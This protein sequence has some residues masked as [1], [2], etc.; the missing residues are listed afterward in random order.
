MSFSCECE[1]VGENGISTSC[2]EER[3]GRLLRSKGD[4]QQKRNTWKGSELDV[5]KKSAQEVKMG[6]CFKVI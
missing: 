2:T 1:V 5:Q 6:D 3:R 4:K